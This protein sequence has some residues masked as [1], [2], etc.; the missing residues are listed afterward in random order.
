M[1]MGNGRVGGGVA[2]CAAIA[3]AVLLS[4]CGSSSGSSGATSSKVVIGMAIGETGP[5]VTY[6]TAAKD[7]AELAVADINAHG[8]LLGHP[9]ELITADTHS[10]I[11][12]GSQAGLA[13]K[14]KGA[15]VILTSP[16]YNYGGGAARVAEQSNMV[17]FSAAGSSK[18]GPSGIGPL[19]YTT[20]YSV[21][22][23]GYVDAE[24][25]Y[26]TQHFDKAYAL[27]DTTTDAGLQQC[28]GFRSHFKELGGTIVGSDTFK[29]S[30]A[31][32]ATQL[33]KLKA[34]DK[35]DVILLCSYPPGGATA[36]QQ[37][38]A[39]GI[40]QP[41]IGEMAFD[42]T[43]WFKK[44]MR[45]LSNFYYVTPTSTYGDDPDPA[46]NAFW[47]SY[48]AKYGTPAVSFGV[49]YYAA[50]EAIAE[51][52]KKAGTVSGSAVAKELDQATGPGLLNISYTPTTH[53][54]VNIPM[55]MMQVQNGKPSYLAT[56]KLASV[57]PQS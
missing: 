50:V 11:N 56:V 38:R 15:N 44:T 29:N 45:N 20:N 27:E 55:R 5:L 57:P 52:I 10:E 53:I 2:W 9:V 19:A 40:D 13:L 7:G 43:Y 39:A 17:V 48:K 51:A 31:S 14:S 22:S 23:E 37:L 30:D 54:L 36:V 28:D 18:F 16:D 46:V 1:T 33:T 41:I 26:T 34:A 12:Q 25:A 8:G 35:P 42:G 24:W 6:D 32:I 4:G 21:T 47:K 3:A 49:N